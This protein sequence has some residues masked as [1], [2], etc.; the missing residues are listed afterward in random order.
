MDDET[1]EFVF[2][3]I[4]K[5]SSGTHMALTIYKAH[6]EGRPIDIIECCKDAK[7]SFENW[8]DQLRGNR[9]SSASLSVADLM[10][11]VDSLARLIRKAIPEIPE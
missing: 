8:L 11:H 9:P 7:E 10:L 3:M 5:F 6:E 1:H 2:D 4:L